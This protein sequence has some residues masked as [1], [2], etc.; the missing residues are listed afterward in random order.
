[1]RGRRICEKA[2]EIRA[3]SYF[4]NFTTQSACTKAPEN[5]STDIL[6]F[7]SWFVNVNKWERRFLRLNTAQNTD[8]I[9]KW[10]K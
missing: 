7:L 4:K 1:M 8:F 2:I 10:L 9:K 3:K 5:P 6:H